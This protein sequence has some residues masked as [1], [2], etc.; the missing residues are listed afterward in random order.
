MARVWT[1]RPRKMN[2]AFRAL[3]APWWRMT[4]GAPT[5]LLIS[6]WTLFVAPGWWLLCLVQKRLLTRLNRR[7]DRQ[8]Y[9]LCGQTNKPRT[10]DIHVRANMIKLVFSDLLLM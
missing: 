9:P 2:R 1:G 8:R 5:I 7:G 4:G 3:I 6:T 10:I